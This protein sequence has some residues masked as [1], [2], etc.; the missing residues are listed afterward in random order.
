MIELSPNSEAEP[1]IANPSYRTHHT[2]ICRVKIQ[3]RVLVVT[4]IDGTNYHFWG[5]WSAHRSMNKTK[6]AVGL[7]AVSYFMH[8]PWNWCNLM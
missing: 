2:S 1:A 8:N 7:I 5:I 6:F 3:V 4:P